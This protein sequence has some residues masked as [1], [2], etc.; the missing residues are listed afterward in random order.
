MSMV[1]KLPGL[2]HPVAHGSLTRLR[3]WAQESPGNLVQ[4]QAPLRY[5][6]GSIQLCISHRLIEDAGAAGVGAT[7]GESRPALGNELYLQSWQEAKP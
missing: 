1:C 5:I 2:W 6:S 7:P 4:M 3:Q